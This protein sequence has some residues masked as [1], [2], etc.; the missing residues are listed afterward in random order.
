[1]TH[2]KWKWISGYGGRYAVSNMGRVRSH[3]RRVGAFGGGTRFISGKIMRPKVA[4]S[5]YPMIILRK[6]GKETTHLIHRLVCEVFVC[7]LGLWPQVNHKNGIKT[8]NR[9]ANLEPST[10][11]ENTRHA[12]EV[13]GKSRRGEKSSAATVTEA[14]AREIYALKGKELQRVTAERFGTTRSVVGHIQ[15]RT[16]W[17]HIHEN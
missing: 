14:Q 17:R 1:M 13:L 10:P 16:G 5:G 9:A 15:R 4:R 7:P 12:I 11:K 8:D 2:E 6:L 3:R